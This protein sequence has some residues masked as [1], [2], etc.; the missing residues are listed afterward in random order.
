MT[1]DLESILIGKSKKEVIE[2]LGK[3]HYINCRYLNTICYVAY[4]PDDWG[5][6]H[7]EFVIH[8]NE[9]NIVIK[10]SKELI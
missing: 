10:F 7:T 5:M 6:D 2:L 1:N 3:D 9:N 4:E 8:F